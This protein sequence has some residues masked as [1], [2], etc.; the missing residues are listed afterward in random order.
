MENGEFKK[1]NVSAA[2]FTMLSSLRWIELWY[3]PSREITP[4]EL[5]NDLKTLLMNG[6]NS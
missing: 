6:L 2:L 1:M 5:E 3:K 4:Q